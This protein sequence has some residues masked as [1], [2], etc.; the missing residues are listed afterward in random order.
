MIK[1]NLFFESVGKILAAF[2]VACVVYLAPKV[3]HWLESNTDKATTDSIVTLVNS[4]AQAA[5]Q[6]LHDDDPTGE[7][8]KLYVTMHLEEA[9]VVVTNEIVS[10]I[11]GAVWN[12]NTEN[13][14]AKGG[15]KE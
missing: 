3:K 5:E 4:F 13:Q 6:L 9:G 15:V 11:E 8:R 10:I 14:K 2:F 12:I 7:K 1:L